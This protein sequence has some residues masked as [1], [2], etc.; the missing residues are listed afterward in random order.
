[1]TVTVPTLTLRCD[2]AVVL[3][4]SQNVDTQ[5]QYQL[6]LITDMNL[7]TSSTTQKRLTHITR[8][9]PR[10]DFHHSSKHMTTAT[11]APTPTRKTTDITTPITSSHSL[12]LMLC[13][14]QSLTN[15]SNAHGQQLRRKALISALALSQKTVRSSKHA[16]IFQKTVC[17]VST[18]R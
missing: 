14:C 4:K 9:I 11:S 2:I 1:M 15:S 3:T 10:E 7:L 13:P 17:M 6:P 5:L 18:Y 16:R 12:Q 8:P